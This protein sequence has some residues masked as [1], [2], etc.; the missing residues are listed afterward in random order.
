[1]NRRIRKYPPITLR[2]WH[3]FC[4]STDYTDDYHRFNLCRTSGPQ[5][6]V[7]NLWSATSGP[8]PPVRNLRSATSG[9]QPPVRNLRSAT[10]GPQSA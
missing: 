1:L 4:L 5:P 2:G 9:P 3:S 6:L 7:R 10:S 8:Q